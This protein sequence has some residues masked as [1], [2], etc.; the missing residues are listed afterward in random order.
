MIHF[1]A[2]AIAIA[3]AIDNCTSIDN[4]YNMYLVCVVVQ[5]DVYQQCIGSKF[6][7]IH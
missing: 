3:I 6:L 7:F 2:I 1:D 5:Y 4:T